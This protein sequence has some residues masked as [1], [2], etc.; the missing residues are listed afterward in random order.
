MTAAAR[1]QLRNAPEQPLVGCA[2]SSVTDFSQPQLSERGE[3]NA[4]IAGPTTNFFNAAMAT[5][6][7]SRVTELSIQPASNRRE[8]KTSE[9]SQCKLLHPVVFD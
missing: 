7:S 4:G 9:E 5:V 1:Q 6:A 2:G 3:K 8:H